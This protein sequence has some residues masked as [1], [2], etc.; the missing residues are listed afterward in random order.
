M[1]ARLSK[2]ILILAATAAMAVPAYAVTTAV[3]SNANSSN[4]VNT[5]RPESR[6][7]F[8]TDLYIRKQV[9]FWELV[10]QKYPSTS[11][12]IHDSE[13][14][15][16]MVDLIDYL[17][18]SKRDESKIPSREERAKTT[19]KYLDRYTI[20]LD[21][22]AKLGK[23]ALKF[24]AI[25]KRVWSVYSRSPEALARL[26][27]GN[28]KLR[29]QT[30]LSDTFLDAATK[31]KDYLPYMETVFR[32]YNLPPKLTRLVFVESMFN[33]DAVSKA[34]A[35]GVWQFMP[36]TGKRFMFV[37]RHVDERNN[38]WKAT[39]AA[40]LYLSDG[41]SE[42]KSWP[43]AITGYNHGRGGLH[44]AIREMGTRDFGVIAKNYR[45]HKS[46][47]FASRNYY[48]EFLAAV[49]TYDWLVR[50]GQIQT[51]AKPRNDVSFVLPKSLTVSEIM[52]LTKLDEQT[53]ATLNPCLT[54]KAFS[55]YRHKPL[56]RNY[57]IRVPVDRAAE[58]KTA[59]KKRPNRSVATR[60]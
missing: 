5:Y 43:L 29:S 28:V 58:I 54:A 10:F 53:L 1:T 17:L 57:E 59:L 9:R 38:P 23:D 32:S 37:D 35:S 47:G 49:S 6:N 56:P 36:Q 11:V 40:A 39:R 24:G 34:G 16:R 42:M 25:E 21:R 8:P 14:P 19:Q 50:T 22:F 46:F 31:S 51:I 52:L 12:I 4:A 3:S 41:F 26:Y 55:Q 30:G 13:E 44:K 2:I 7:S 27:E 45:G 60:R 18:F 48:G 20:A 33:L 15:D